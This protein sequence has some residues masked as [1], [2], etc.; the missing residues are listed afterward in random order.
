[1]AQFHMCTVFYIHHCLCVMTENDVLC[2]YL[3]CVV[4]QSYCSLM[5]QFLDYMKRTNGEG[6]TILFDIDC[7]LDKLRLWIILIDFLVV[8]VVVVK[9]VEIIVVM[10]IMIVLPKYVCIGSAVESTHFEK[11]PSTEYCVL[12]IYSRFSS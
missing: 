6:H 7:H 12:I 1:M 10:M 5:I 11:P 8:V 9:M 4:Y 3:I 2:M